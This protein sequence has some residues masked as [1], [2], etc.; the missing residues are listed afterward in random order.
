VIDVP[1]G[2]VA[3][4]GPI[5]PDPRTKFQDAYVLPFPPTRSTAIV[6][7]DPAIRV[8]IPSIKFEGIAELASLP[9]VPIANAS[10]LLT[11][12]L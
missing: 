12:K 10:I 11:I 8:I 2:P 7:V 4:V 6:I 1:C 5:D 9:R 3:P